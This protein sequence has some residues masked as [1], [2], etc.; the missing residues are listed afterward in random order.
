MLKCKYGAIIK[1][2]LNL[3]LDGSEFTSTPYIPEKNYRNSGW[4]KM[5]VAIFGEEHTI[6]DG[7]EREEFIG[8]SFKVQFCKKEKNGRVSFPMSHILV[9]GVETELYNPNFLTENKKSY[10]EKQRGEA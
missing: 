2:M 6:D 3:E 1:F 5:C 10:N 4:Y 7:I 9:D 8:K